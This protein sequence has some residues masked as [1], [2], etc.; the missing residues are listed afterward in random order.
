ME[1][2][3]TKTTRER[4]SARPRINTSDGGD[5]E[6]WHKRAIIRYADVVRLVGEDP[7]DADCEKGNLYAGCSERSRY[8]C[9][10]CYARREWDEGVRDI[11]RA[12]TDWGLHRFGCDSP[13]DCTGRQFSHGSSV[14][15]HKR[16]PGVVVVT[17][18]GGLDI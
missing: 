17:W 4:I 18:S 2:T 5:Y 3:E 7:V 10:P 1:A 11:V 9:D 15:R 16:H 13:Y 14:Y 6:S 8:P 12:A